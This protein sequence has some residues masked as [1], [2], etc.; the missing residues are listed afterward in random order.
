MMTNPRM[1]GPTPS[2]A[3]P[4]VAHTVDF[5]VGV[6]GATLLERLIEPGGV[7]VIFAALRFGAGLLYLTQAAPGQRPDAERTGLTLHLAVADAED[8]FTRAVEA[9]AE[10]VQGPVDAGWGERH[11]RFRDP[12]GILWSVSQTVPM[13]NLL[14]HTA[15]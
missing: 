6:L 14:S 10:V 4:D 15:A 13:R 3:V 9:G 1:P 8:T 2:L 5:H 12:A 11:A 7:R